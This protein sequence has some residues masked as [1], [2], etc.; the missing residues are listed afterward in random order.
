MARQG[1]GRLK[2]ARGLHFACLGFCV[3]VGLPLAVGVRYAIRKG[4]PDCLSHR[5]QRHVLLQKSLLSSQSEECGYNLG[6]INLSSSLR[7]GCSGIVC[8]KQGRTRG[9]YA[10]D[11]LCGTSRDQVCRLI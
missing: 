6:Q 8:S 7:L 9:S 2:N 10:V 3:G 4:Q 5:C 11:R 1:L